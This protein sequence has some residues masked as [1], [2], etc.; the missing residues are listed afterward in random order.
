VFGF[1]GRVF[2]LESRPL[3]PNRNV[4]HHADKRPSSVINSVEDIG[5]TNTENYGR[6]RTPTSSVHSQDDG[7]DSM[8]SDRISD[9][10]WSLGGGCPESYQYE[11]LDSCLI[12][13]RPQKLDRVSANVRSSTQKSPAL[14]PS[15]RRQAPPACNQVELYRRYP[16]RSSNDPGVIDIG[17][18]V[19]DCPPE[20]EEFSLGPGL[21]ACSDPARNTAAG[22]GSR[23]LAQGDGY[24]RRQSNGP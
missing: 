24:L 14:R 20:I 9:E 15:I 22:R 8:K 2:V 13:H 21:P 7:P 11:N 10:R 16:R 6:D 19:A 1:Q 17:E 18:S 4:K 12:Q 23:L 3:V 5:F